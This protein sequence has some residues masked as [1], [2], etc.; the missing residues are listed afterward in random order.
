MPFLLF[1]ALQLLGLRVAESKVPANK[2]GRKELDGETVSPL[3][4]NEASQMEEW[5]ERS[6]WELGQE[7]VDEVAETHF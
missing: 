2:R 5:N 6:E 1:D 4:R 7:G 3:N